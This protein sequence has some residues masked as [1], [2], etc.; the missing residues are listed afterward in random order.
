MTAVPRFNRRGIF[1]K[2]EMHMWVA[3]VIII[4]LAMIAVGV[5]ALSDDDQGRKEK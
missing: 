4:A 2:G 1:H 3:A 5:F